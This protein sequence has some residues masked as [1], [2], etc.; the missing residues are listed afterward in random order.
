MVQ[1]AMLQAVTIDVG[2]SVYGVNITSL[3]EILPMMELRPIPKGPGFIEGVINLRG[4]ILPVVDLT[5]QFGLARDGYS[6]ES[7]ILVSGVSPRR[8][9]FVVEAVQEIREIPLSNIVRSQMQS[10]EANFVEGMAKLS[11]SEL[12]PL[13]AIQKA[14]KEEDW[15]KIAGL[16]IAGE[17]K[18]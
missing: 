3:D 17:T 4:D 16:E 12:I 8:A 6:L 5:K 2:G 14:L 7:R 15:E 18:T 10:S 11:E 13:I 9:G 1:E